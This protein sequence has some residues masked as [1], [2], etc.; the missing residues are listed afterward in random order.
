MDLKEY[1]GQLDRI[2]GEIIRLFKERMETVSKIAEYK[3]SNGLP[4]LA[5]GREQEILDRI[6]AIAGEDLQ[7]YAKKLFT[8]LM[9]L[10]RDYQAEYLQAANSDTSTT[11][12]DT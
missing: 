2:D 12:R 7:E 10:S 3:K 6:S 11:N 9:A 1:R 8:T 5:A 4:I